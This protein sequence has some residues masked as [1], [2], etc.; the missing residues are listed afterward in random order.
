MKVCCN[1]MDSELA[2][3]HIIIL[4][5]GRYF[6]QCMSPIMYCPFCGIELESKQEV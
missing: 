1:G 3:E 4:S 5:D 6:L 2:E